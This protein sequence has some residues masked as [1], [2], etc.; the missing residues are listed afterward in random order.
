[1]SYWDTNCVEVQINP[2]KNN[3]P[4][5]GVGGRKYRL[6]RLIFA[7]H[8]GEIPE[9]MLVCHHCDNPK[10]IN[11]EH[12][13]LG[14]SKDNMQDMARKSRANGG[15]PHGIKNHKSK[16]DFNTIKWIRKNYV[17]RS[18]FWGTNALARYFNV[19]QSS[20]YAIV[21]HQHR[22]TD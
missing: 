17:P 19:S 16:F 18:T 13:F 7:S 1:M 8:F 2:D 5:I 9:D 20:V 22:K 6:A 21:K 3:Y 11:Y 14:T 10:C 15:P 4:R 12:L